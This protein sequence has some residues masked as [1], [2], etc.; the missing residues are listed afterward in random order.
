VGVCLEDMRDLEALLAREAEVLVDA[1]APG[2]D[3]DRLPGVPAADEVAQA[4]R[5]LVQELLEYHGAYS[6]TTYP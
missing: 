2:V 1:V 5:V 3:H 6:T 4:A